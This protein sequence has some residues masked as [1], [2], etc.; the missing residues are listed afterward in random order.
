MAHKA[1]CAKTKDPNAACDKGCE[2]VPATQIC[3]DCEQEIGANETVCPKCKAD[4]KLAKEED[5]TI[6]RSL[7]R[8][9]RKKKKERPVP[10][11]EPNPGV[12]TAKRSIFRALNR[13]K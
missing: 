12:P 7:K 4:L 1:E 3:W 11:P 13:F 2:T 9:A 5:D 10:T 6:G 8:L